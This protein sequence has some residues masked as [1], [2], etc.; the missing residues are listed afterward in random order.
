MKLLIYI[1]VYIHVCRTS[2]VSPKLI[3]HIIIF[4]FSFQICS[5]LKLS[6]AFVPEVREF[7]ESFETI[8]NNFSQ[9][10]YNNLS[11]WHF[12]YFS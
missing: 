11:F 1:Y 9:V 8:E 4:S 6:T 2:Y 7:T 12:T 5:L 10:Y 3:F